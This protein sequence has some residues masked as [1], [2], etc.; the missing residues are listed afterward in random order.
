MRLFAALFFALSSPVLAQ[1]NLDTQTALFQFNQQNLAVQLEQKEF[2][3]IYRT[4]QVP[5]TCYRDE[6]QGTK[7]EC[8]TEFDRQCDTRFEQSCYFRNYPICRSVPRN[9]CHT[10]NQCTTQMDR[11]CNSSGCRSVPR[12]VCNPV[13]RC[14]TQMDQVCRNDQRYECQTV[15]RQYCQDI[16]R[17]VCNQVPNIVKVPYACTRPVQVPIGQQI[18][19]HTIARVSILLENF[20]QTGAISDQLSARLV[21]G[22]VTL[23]GLNQSAHTHLFQMVKTDRT[24]QFISSTEKQVNYLFQIKAIPVQNLNRFLESKLSDAKLYS[25]RLEF[26]STGSLDAPFKGKLLIV[27]KRRII[28]DKVVVNQ[29]FSP[30]AIVGRSSLQSISLS[31]FG[32][33]SLKDAKYRVELSLKLDEA[34]L[35]SNLINTETL[36]R[37][38]GKEVATTFDADL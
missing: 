12:R 20:T 16:P 3:T 23:S 21:N 37:I 22:Q 38:I 29:E 18:K 30:S 4:D 35:K 7:T 28:S 5:D 27:Q 10:S 6:V 15:P 17:Q 34:Q 26:N 13:Q 32:V 36:S 1:T 31:Q 9:V 24:E 25:D 33:E 19:L 2:E 8:H 11:V 14:N